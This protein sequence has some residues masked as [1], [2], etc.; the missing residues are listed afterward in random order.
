VPDVKG[1]MR[2]TRRDVLRYTVVLAATGL[3]APLAS[4]AQPAAAPTAAPA[5]ATEA[6]KPA[7]TAAP[8]PAATTAPA[9]AAATAAPAATQAPALGDAFWKQY[10]GTSLKIVSNDHA[11]PKAVIAKLPEFEK[12]T[13]MKVDIELLAWT[14]YLQRSD[15]E[16]SS[17]SGAYDM[18]WVPFIMTTRWLSANWLAP[19]S[20]LMDNAK[21]TAKELLAL[22]D[23]LPTALNV[24]KKDNTTYSLPMLLNTQIMF[25]RTDQFAKAGISAPPD[26]Y[27]DLVAACKKIHSAEIAGF[28]ARGN[29]AEIHWNFPMVMQSY[30][31]NFFKDPPKDMTPT[32]NTPAAV[33]AAEVYASLLSDYSLP[34]SLAFAAADVMANFQQGRAAFF[35]EDDVYLTQALD[36]TKSKVYDKIVASRVPKGPVARA[37]QMSVHGFGIPTKAKNKEATWLFMQWALS[38]EMMLYAMDSQ[39]NSGM[40]RVSVMKSKAYKDKFTVGG[41]D[42]GAIREEAFA[43]VKIAYRLIPEFSPIGDR[44][45]VAIQQIA[46]KQKT[47]QQ[48]MDEA[49]KDIT[50]ILVKAG[51]KF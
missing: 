11:Y 21:I 18:V 3:V 38:P 16:M 10:S 1:S 4:C 7:A 49:Q 27:D 20:P 23:Y 33:K 34:G 19:L 22:D 12:L 36:K 35:I 30:G 14:V 47:A 40:T 6:P 43:N 32:F 39:N 15:L 26:T 37:P 44:V 29:P 28:I 45:G 5:K 8:A 51:Y 42:I 24:G 2:L 25:S 48:A 46:S 41:G 13:G 9:P 50:D 31:G 17:A